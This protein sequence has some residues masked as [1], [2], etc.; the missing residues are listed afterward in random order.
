LLVAVA[1][2][3]WWVERA[4]TFGELLA[5]AAVFGLA[6][7]AFAAGVAWNSAWFPDRQR[8]MA[9]GIF[10]AGNVGASLTKLLVPLALAMLPSA[11]LLGG[12]VPGGWRAV[13]AAYAV[14]LL[15][16]AAAVW[17]GSPTPD[18]TP[19]R[20]RPLGE[21]LAPVRH[22]RVWRLSLYYVVVFGA[23]VALAAWLPAYYVDVHGLGLP[24]AGAWTVAFIVP[25]SLLRPVGGWLSDRHGARSVTSAVFVVIAAALAVLSLPRAVLDPGPTGFGVLTVVVGSAMGI[26]KGSVFKY[27]PDYF[28]RDVGAVGG[29]VGMLG[30][31]GGFI[32]PPVFGALGRWTGSP[33]S[34]FLALLALTLGSLLWLHLVVRRL[35]A[36]APPACRPAV[37]RVAA[38][39]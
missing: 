32:L 27:V 15:L 7:N 9:L 26:G 23:Y 10:G 39:R 6:G 34:A 5:C 36:V 20:G 28:P 13:P 1:P 31:L 11:G 17:W 19:A 24:L 14:L 2:A 4:G 8:G 30:A 12:W 37:A 22:I 35:N 16:T 21:L 38:G 18:R 3:A 33:Q 29:M 25:A